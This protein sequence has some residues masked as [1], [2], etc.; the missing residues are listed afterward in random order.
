MHIL[1]TTTAQPAPTYHIE[2]VS[3]NT[4]HLRISELIQGASGAYVRYRYEVYDLRVV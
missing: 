1:E 2:N 3:Q 4:S